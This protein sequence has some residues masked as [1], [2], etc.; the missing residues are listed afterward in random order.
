MNRVPLPRERTQVHALT[1]A[2]LAR[3]F[4]NEMTGGSTDL[5]HAFFWLLAALAIPGLAMP[6][7]A[8]NGWNIIALAPG[9]EGGLDFLRRYVSADLT[10]SLGV[11]MI[12]IGLMSAISWQSLLL[13]RRDV[14]VLG[15][16]PVRYRTVLT[17]KLCSLGL[18]FGILV[19]A[20]IPLSAACYG[21]FLGTAFSPIEGFQVAIVHAGVSS[22]AALATYLCVIAL[23]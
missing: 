19:V 9:P 17:A 10:F 23:Q 7:A 8:G 1:R 6:T 14:Q 4:D 22:L 20:S 15:S 18:F 16:F 5:Q 13:E 21:L 2:F 11:T 3:F 12:G